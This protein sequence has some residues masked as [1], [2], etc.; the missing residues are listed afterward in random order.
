MPS[1]KFGITKF[2]HYTDEELTHF[3]LPPSFTATPESTKG[4]SGQVLP[5]AG[6]IPDYFDWRDHDVVTS[7]KDQQSCG[8]CYA[9]GTAAVVETMHAIN[10]GILTN[11]SEQQITDCDTTSHGCNGGY[12]YSSMN[13]V[14]D[15]GLVPLED[16]PYENRQGAC[17]T[18][19]NSPRTTIRGNI[20]LPANEDTIAQMVAYHGP[21]VVSKSF[22]IQCLCYS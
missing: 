9:F 14:R 13:L 6:P 5:S 1:A 3:L 19:E 22:L 4:Y 11:L 2:T 12:L 10:T 8:D 21:V 16:Y 15:V 17:R 7:V 18:P 20:W